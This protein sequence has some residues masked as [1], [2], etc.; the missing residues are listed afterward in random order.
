MLFVRFLFGFVAVCSAALLRE[1]FFE[2]LPDG[3]RHVSM[4]VYYHRRPILPDAIFQGKEIVNSWKQWALEEIDSKVV[5]QYWSSVVLRWTNALLKRSV[6][7]TTYFRAP[8]ATQDTPLNSDTNIYL[9][10]VYKPSVEFHWA[11]E[12]ENTHFQLVKTHNSTDAHHQIYKVVCRPGSVFP[13]RLLVVN[14]QDENSFKLVWST[15]PDHQPWRAKNPRLVKMKTQTAKKVV[16]S[17]FHRNPPVVK[18]V[19]QPQVNVPLSRSLP[20]SFIRQHVTSFTLTHLFTLDGFI[21]PRQTLTRFVLS[22]TTPVVIQIHEAPKPGAPK[23][24]MHTLL[25]RKNYANE[26]VVELDPAMYHKITVLGF[27]TSDN[28]YE[29]SLMACDPNDSFVCS[30]TTLIVPGPKQKELEGQPLG[31]G[32]EVQSLNFG[33][34]EQLLVRAATEAPDSGVSSI[35]SPGTSRKSDARSSLGSMVNSIPEAPPLD[36]DAQSLLGSAANSI[37][38]AP[39]FDFDARSPLASK[40]NSI[41][42]PPPFDFDA[43]SL[44]GSAANSI[45]DAPPFDF[46]ARSP[47]GSA[48]NSILEPPPLDLKAAIENFNRVYKEASLDNG[49]VRK[50]FGKKNMRY[51]KPATVASPDSPTQETTC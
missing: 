36:F 14:V 2:N 16:T 37:P 51:L 19:R 18:L 38:E 39:P 46:D 6:Y 25:A 35:G 13:I 26:A 47:L 7:F 30:E 45:P 12:F 42:D 10:F 21:K 48:A 29:F 49:A 28:Q 33:T 27:M 32:T 15:D 34:E 43:Q 3:P 4:E 5:K 9:C 40:A 24:K 31:S 17:N 22:G 41:P 1:S 23:H 44:L 8:Q 11:P 20:Q 50:E